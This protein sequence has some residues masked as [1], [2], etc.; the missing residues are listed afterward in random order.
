MV[1]DVARTYTNMAVD[2]KQP[3]LRCRYI[4]TQHTACRS[5][6]R[7]WNVRNDHS[8]E[9]ETAV[10]HRTCFMMAW[11]TLGK[12]F[13]SKDFPT[14]FLGFFEFFDDC[15]TSSYKARDGEHFPVSFIKFA[16]I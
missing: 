2:L 3:R 10:S 14:N 9:S 15:F 4:K 6:N 5:I 13:L 12:V 7:Q 1:T 8:N 11:D 16:K